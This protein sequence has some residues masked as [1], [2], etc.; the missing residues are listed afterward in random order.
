MKDNRKWSNKKIKEIVQNRYSQI[1]KQNN[2]CCG[3]K[4]SCCGPPDITAHIGKTTGYGE[5]E[6]QSVPENANLGLGC[7]NPV[8]LA[9]LLQGETVLD[10]GAGA[11]FDCF[12]AAKRVGDKGKVIGIDMTKE[13]VE[14]AEENARKGPYANVEFRL[15]EIENLPVET[16]SVD[17][18]I[19]NCV[20][21]LSPD[22]KRVFQEA[23][24]VLRPGGRL[25]ISDL[26]LLKE[27]PESIRE[28]VQAYT[29]CIAGAMKKD[30]YLDLIK[31][32]GF[33]ELDIK[34]EDYFSPGLE[35]EDAMT[36]AIAQ[37]AGIPPEELPELAR[38]VLSI[39]LH[40]RK[41]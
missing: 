18:I 17:V 34:K 11:G 25:M 21:N 23:F 32:S 8:A 38:S 30:E 16:E 5:E 41:P 36:K 15:G 27:L 29:G 1:A 22:K 35:S 12:L 6:L 14:K 26:V 3:Q 24:R 13:M 40:A 7:G 37:E 10:L 33:Q 9:S 4:E 2:S 19:S 31:N 20:I 39:S 28:S